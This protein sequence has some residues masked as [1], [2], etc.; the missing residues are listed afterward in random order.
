M[1]TVKIREVE[2]KFSRPGIAVPST[3]FAV[4]MKGEHLPKLSVQ[5][6]NVNVLAASFIVNV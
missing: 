3:Y 5:S 4:Y 1:V 6:V 2:S